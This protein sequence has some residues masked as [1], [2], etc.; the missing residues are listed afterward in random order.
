MQDK[1]LKDAKAPVDIAL[2]FVLPSY[3]W[4]LRSMEAVERRMDSLI[5]HAGVLLAAFPVI[6]AAIVGEQALHISPFSVGTALA[7][8][9]AAFG[10][11]YIGINKRRGAFYFPK[12]DPMIDEID[13]S[14]QP[15]L[16][17]RRLVVSARN[18]FET[19]SD[20]VAQK[21]GWAGWMAVGL[22]LEIILG[23]AWI[24]SI[25]V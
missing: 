11:F 25:L 24:V 20:L 3:E 13:K 19:N 9:L 6:V 22:L 7:T 17:K 5:L 16:M 23:S 21:A 8:V 12:I 4:A 1:G 2:V 14:V 15:S 18:A 10:V